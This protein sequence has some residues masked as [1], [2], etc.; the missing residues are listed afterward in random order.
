LVFALIFYVGLR[1]LVFRD[2]DTLRLAHRVAG[3]R[4]KLLSR[5]LPAAPLS[6]A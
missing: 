6:N 2:A 5:L 3:Q 1:W 4:L